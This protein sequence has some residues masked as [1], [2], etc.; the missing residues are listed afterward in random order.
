[1]DQETWKFILAYLSDQENAERKQQLNEWLAKDPL[2]QQKFEQAK[3]LWQDTAIIQEDEQWKESFKTIREAVKPVVNKNVQPVLNKKALWLKLWPITAAAAIS[4][5]ILFVFLFKTHEPVSTA[6]NPT[7]W[8]LKTAEPGEIKKVIL[9]D[10]TEIWLNAG[11]SVRFPENLK[12]AAI[13]TVSLT[14]EAFFKVKKDPLHPFVVQSSILRTRVLGTSFNIRAWAGHNAEVTVLT[15]KVA[16]SKDSAGIQTAM[17]HLLPNQKAVYNIH[18]AL[19]K[20]ENAADTESAV[21]W[22]TGKMVFDQL[23]VKEVLETISRRY[24]VEIMT[25]DS[26]DGCKLTARFNNVS[27]TE[28]MKTLKLTLDI[29]Y[30][31]NQH[32]I[33]IKGGKCN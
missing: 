25:K 32:T 14:G 33:Y 8:I 11:S 15:G 30:T 20:K 5:A 22:T 19:L 13:R 27:L 3:L 24:G 7:T 29:H 16:V 31:I 10:S 21:S 2:H 28:V 23:P 17:V 26:F 12:H 6:V 9:P 1:M 4:G 18:S